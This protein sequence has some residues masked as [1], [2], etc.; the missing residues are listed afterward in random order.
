[1]ASGQTSYVQPMV[2]ALAGMLDRPLNGVQEVE[3]KTVG[4]AQ[5]AGIGEGLG[6]TRVADDTVGLPAAAGDITGHFQGV[7]VRLTA[8]EPHNGSAIVDG[9]AGMYI[10]KDQIPVLRTGVIW[11]P[12]EAAANQDDPVY[13]RHTA[14]G[15]LNVI[16]GFANAAGTG[17]ALV[18]G[19]KVLDTIAAAGLAR[20]KLLGV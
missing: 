15:G 16:G 14:N 5:A 12:F 4:A 13:C 9:G 2:Q 7:S 1:M 3:S 8:R 11:V 18:T 19:A 10:A 6:L 20:I 17:L